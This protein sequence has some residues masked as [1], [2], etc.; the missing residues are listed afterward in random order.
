MGAIFSGGGGS[1][2]PPPVDTS[3]IVA[4]QQAAADAASNAAQNRLRI[5]GGIS[6]LNGPNGFVGATGNQ[7]NQTLGGTP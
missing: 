4:Q 6:S 3:A 1:S 5:S 2:A 7:T